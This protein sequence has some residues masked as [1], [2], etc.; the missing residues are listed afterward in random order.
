MDCELTATLDGVGE[1]FHTTLDLGPSE[2]NREVRFQLERPKY[3]DLIHANN[4][5]LTL[6]GHTLTVR[7]RSGRL[8]RANTRLRETMYNPQTDAAR[9]AAQQ[10]AWARHRA[11][12]CTEG[13][14][15]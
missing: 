13:T 9:Y 1:V 3:G 4:N 15:P 10:E 14:A 11:R 6:Y 5:E 8:W 12:G 2:L 7:V